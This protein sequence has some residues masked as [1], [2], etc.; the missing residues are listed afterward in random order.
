MSTQ[1]NLISLRKLLISFRGSLC[2][3]V[4]FIISPYQPMLYSSSQNEELN[5]FDMIVGALEEIILG[6]P[7]VC[8]TNMA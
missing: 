7:N 8:D 3:K 1:G 2:F 6:S 4:R 5:R